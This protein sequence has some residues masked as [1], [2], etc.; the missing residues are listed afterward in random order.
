[1]LDRLY[2]MMVHIKSKGTHTWMC[3]PVG[4]GLTLTQA[5]TLASGPGRGI[6]DNSLDMEY[7]L[8]PSDISSCVTLKYVDG[9]WTPI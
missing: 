2:T 4:W 1:M 5:V 7:N 6:P 3:C 8:I 9:S